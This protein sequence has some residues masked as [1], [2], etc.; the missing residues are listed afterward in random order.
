MSI[1]PVKG[2]HDLYG[3]DALALRYVEGVLLSVAELYGYREI[4]LPDFEYT[5]V[6]ERG[7]GEG[8]DVVRKEMYTFKDKG[9]RSLTLRPEFTAG[10]A[11]SVISNRFYATEDLPF[12]VYYYGPLFRY[13]RP[14]LGRY[15]QFNQFGVEAIGEDSARLDAETI[16][17]AVQSLALL[18][19]KDITLKINSLGDE[20]SRKNYR[21]ALK[22]YFKEH[23]DSMCEDCKERLELN[24]LRILDCK[25]EADQ[26]IAKN[27]PKISSYLS[28]TSEKRFYETLSILNDMGVKYEKDE[29]LVRGLDYYSE[30]VFE[31]HAKAPSGNDYG[32]LLGGGHYASLLK[33][34]GGPNLPGVGF[35]MG[36]ERL[37]A[38]LKEEGLLNNLDDGIDI[39]VMPIGQEMIENADHLAEE[40]RMYGY[41]TEVPFGSLKFSSLFKKAER[42][43]AKFALILGE[44]EMKKGVA[45]LKELATKTQKE[46]CLDNLE[47]ELETAF[48]PYSEE[49]H[50]CDC[51][52][53]GCSCHEHE[54]S[55]HHE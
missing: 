31:V 23:I 11:R 5:D 13:E 14:Q 19:F 36:V 37:C 1:Q 50:H 12:K 55:C 40:C 16:M 53:E 20:E 8:S 52:E 22:N 45:Q 24:P 15:R 21:E 25:V 3:Q 46:I 42:R 26:E 29:S 47:E 49:E 39:Y 41:K 34:L 32:A 9:D 6:F 38:V 54:C 28:E 43:K 33:E 17:V 35:A 18:G 44:D 51:E 7:T 10:V 4:I 2:T 30:V 27:A 48:A